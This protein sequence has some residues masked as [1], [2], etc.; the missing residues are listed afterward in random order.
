[1]NIG[2]ASPLAVSPGNL[3][4][5]SPPADPGPVFPDA[6]SAG[7]VDDA[8]DR[9]R[10]TCAWRSGT[11]EALA[12]GRGLGTGAEALAALGVGAV[13]LAGAGVAAA[14]GVF[15]A[16]TGASGPLGGSY[17]G[18]TCGPGV[19][20]HVLAGGADSV[21]AGTGSDGVVDVFAAA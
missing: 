7:T 14:G 10:S 16:G 20:C 2:A 6:C 1:M 17:F 11:V 4:S 9:G 5:A 15:G 19:P 3:G 12:G 18:A 8:A 13:A 21:T